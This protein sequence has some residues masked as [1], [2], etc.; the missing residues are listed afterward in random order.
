MLTPDGVFVVSTLNLAHN[1]KRKATYQTPPFHEKEFLPHEL[2][3]LL[4][5]VFPVV[6]LSGLYP[7]VR[8]RLFHRLKKWGMDRW[9]SPRWNL[10]RR[11]YD[12]LDTGEFVLRRRCS[13]GAID[14]IAICRLS[15]ASGGAHG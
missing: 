4:R 10:V 9:G 3:T 7:G 2:Q 11:F 8:H 12:R 15:P 5:Q 1:Q 13:P 14:L 6:E